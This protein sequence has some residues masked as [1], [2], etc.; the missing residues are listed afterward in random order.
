MLVEL[1]QSDRTKLLLESEKLVSK[2]LT[3]D[4][5]LNQ[6]KFDEENFNLQEIKELAETQSLFGNK[7][8]VII[9]GVPEE[10]EEEFNEIRKNLENSENFFILRIQNLAPAKKEYANTFHF[11]DAI[12]E[13][14]KKRAWIIYQEL[15]FAGMKGEELFYKVM[16]LIKTMLLAGKVGEKESGLNPFVY[17]KAKSFLRNWKEGEV[18]SLSESLVVEYHEA[19]RGNKEIETLVEKAILR[20]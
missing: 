14:N 8:L 16:W 13:R 3:E 17:K 12:G 6:R 7:S 2:Y 4:P 15:L 18:E 9:D 11:T 5:G 20:L 19:R 1:T 10:Y